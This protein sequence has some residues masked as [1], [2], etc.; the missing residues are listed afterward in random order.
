MAEALGKE[1]TLQAVL[2]QLKVA[3][4]LT[5]G[6]KVDLTHMGTEI[7]KQRSDAGKTHNWAKKE[8]KGEDKEMQDETHD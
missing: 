1:S 6:M 2:D 8:N 5:V 7:K 4:D 3:N